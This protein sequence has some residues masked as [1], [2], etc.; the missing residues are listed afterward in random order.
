MKGDSVVGLWTKQRNNE[1]CCYAIHNTIGQTQ[2]ADS[3]LTTTTT[4]ST[5]QNLASS[6]LFTTTSISTFSFVPMLVVAYLLLF[7]SLSTPVFSSPIVS[8]SGQH[9]P[10]NQTLR[11]DKELHK[12]KSIRAYLRK[13]NKPAVKTIQ[14]YHY[15][16]FL[17]LKWVSSAKF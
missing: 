9:F 10:A 8:D 11:P 7:A 4:T 13:I 17:L 3:K 14:A 2:N 16:F 1:A 6:L 15:N 5:P 12:L